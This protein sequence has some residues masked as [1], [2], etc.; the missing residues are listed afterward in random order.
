MRCVIFAASQPQGRYWL[1]H[2]ENRGENWHGQVC[3]TPEETWHA[4]QETYAEVCLLCPG[5]AEGRLA[6]LLAQRPLLSPPWLVHAGDEIPTGL[7]PQVLIS[8]ER[9][10]CLARGLLHALTATSALRAAAFLPDMAA[11]AVAHPPLMRSLRTG[12]Y[13]LVARRH[14]TTPAAV[15]RSLRTLVESTWSHGDLAALERFFGCTVDPERGKPTNKEFLRCLQ[16]RL[17][18]AYRR[19]M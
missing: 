6:Q 14:G 17:T 10:T 4:L 1:E 8:L 15:E 12:L 16:E 5:A 13:P 3:L 11:L 9:L 18:L 2:M 19:L 7:P